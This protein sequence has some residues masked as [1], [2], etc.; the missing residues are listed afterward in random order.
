M[1][2][3][4]PIVRNMI[5]E[6]YKCHNYLELHDMANVNLF[7]GENNAGKTSILE[8]LNIASAINW[9]HANLRYPNSLNV[10][11]ELKTVLNSRYSF[12]ILQGKLGHRHFKTHQNMIFCSQSSS[13]NVIK[14][15]FDRS[16]GDSIDFSV[17]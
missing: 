13:S 3:E 1:S 12:E 14:I 8:I 7:G 11:D 4:K 17:V 6:G 15:Y 2:N 16:N 9:N 5:I 10:I